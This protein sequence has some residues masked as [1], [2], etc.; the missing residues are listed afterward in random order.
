MIRLPIIMSAT[1]VVI[2]AT[3][4][5]PEQKTMLGAPAVYQ[6]VID[7]K[8]SVE[9]KACTVLDWG[10]PI[11]QQ[12]IA[13]NTLTAN[14]KMLADAAARA[15][16]GYCANRDASWQ[17]RAVAAADELSKVLWDIYK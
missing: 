5:T 3:A 2:A 11:A 12:R 16:V 13:G 17:Q 6:T 15:A 1:V 14:Q 9:T 7:P 10:L 4:C 8:V